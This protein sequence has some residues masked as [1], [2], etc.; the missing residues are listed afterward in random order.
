MSTAET[1][2]NHSSFMKEARAHYRMRGGK[3]LAILTGLLFLALLFLIVQARM[4]LIPT[5]TPHLTM[6]S[7]LLI[8]ALMLVVVSYAVFRRATLL[9]KR[10]HDGVLG[11]RL[12]SRIIVMFSA[13][14]ILPTLARQA[15]LGSREGT[16][17]FKDTLGLGL[18]LA[19]TL[20]LPAAVG[21]FVLA[22][23]PS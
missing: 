4:K 8:L 19:V 1:I 7:A 21:L 17:A 22:S 6:L 3:A 18:R 5:M 20:I 13:I 11:T 10:A 14:A 9:W 23:P 15:A 2:P 12:Q 16:Q